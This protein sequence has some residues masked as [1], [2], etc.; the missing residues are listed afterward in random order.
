MGKKRVVWIGGVAGD[1]DYPHAACVSFVRALLD[2]AECHF[3]GDQ[4]EIREKASLVKW[5]FELWGGRTPI[6]T[7]TVDGNALYVVGLEIEDEPHDND[8]E[9]G[10]I[11][12]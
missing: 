10:V 8:D 7:A 2:V 3:V 9:Y 4:R 6:F 11:G 5:K 1:G 12:R